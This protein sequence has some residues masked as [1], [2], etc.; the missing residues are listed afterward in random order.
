MEITQ[1]SWDCSRDFSIRSLY[2]EIPFQ[3]PWKLSPNVANQT[4]PTFLIHHSITR[5]HIPLG[6][7]CLQRR[8]ARSNTVLVVPIASRTQDKERNNTENDSDNHSSVASTSWESELTLAR[9]ILFEE[10]DVVHVI[11]DQVDFAAVLAIVEWNV[12][13]LRIHYKWDQNEYSNQ[14]RMRTK[15]DKK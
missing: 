9:A 13:R 15:N 4:T 7:R 11:V 6:D 5:T 2:W 1:W 10:I 14:M 8:V 3:F 12:L